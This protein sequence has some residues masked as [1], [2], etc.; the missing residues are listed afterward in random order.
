MRESETTQAEK[1]RESYRD[2]KNNIYIHRCTYICIE[3]K[4]GRETV[5]ERKSQRERKRR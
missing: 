1:E 5:R 4:S 3:R 2:R